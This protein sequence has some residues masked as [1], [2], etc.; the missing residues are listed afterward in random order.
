MGQS[1]GRFGFRPVIILLSIMNFV[2]YLFIYIWVNY[3]HTSHPKHAADKELYLCPYECTTC[4]ATEGRIVL[5]LL[6]HIQPT[7]TLMYRALLV[8]LGD[9]STFII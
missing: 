7:Y 1:G 5:R 3:E 4:A 2:M 6:R 9:T 8:N